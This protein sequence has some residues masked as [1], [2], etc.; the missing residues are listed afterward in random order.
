VG[1]LTVSKTSEGGRDP[2]MQ[3]LSNPITALQWHGAEVLDVPEGATVLASTDACPIQSFRYGDHAY[4]LQFHVEVTRDT[5]PE[6]AAIPE[7]AAAL[8]RA[9]G[10]GATARLTQQVDGALPGFNQ[11]ARTMYD[12]LKSV[13]SRS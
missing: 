8:E 9:M 3:N 10:A 1:V 13:W 12:N 11:D 5:V 4:G 2:M 7:Y 6:W